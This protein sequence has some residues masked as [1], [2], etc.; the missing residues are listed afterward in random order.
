[1]STYSKKGKGWRYDFMLNG[2]RYTQAWFKTKREAK[3]A[4]T[5]KR[6][7]VLEPPLAATTD[8]GFLELVNRRLDHMKAYNSKAHYDD[9]RYRCKPWVQLWGHLECS[10]I[11]RE[12][13]QAFILKRSRV[14]ACTANRD[15]VSLRSLFNFGR[16]QNL[17]TVNPTEGIESLPIEKKVKY[18]PPLEDIF[19]VIA[20]AEPDTQDYLWTIRETMARVSE[21]N[22]L[23]WDDDVDLEGRYVILYTRKKK[24]GHLT[25]RKVPMTEHLF[26]I[27]SRRYAQRNKQMPYV[28]WY[29]YVSRKTGERCEG[30]YTRR[31]RLMKG[32]CKKAGVRYFNF[33]A[34]RHSGASV[35]DS[36]G[37][38]IGSIQRILGHENRTTT[39][40]YLQSIGDSERQAMAVFE[41]A[42]TNS[43]TD[44]HTAVVSK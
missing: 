26:K 1:M 18:I 22:R 30:P 7:E 44:S 38:P 15:M 2:V 21:V 35:M 10:E 9:Y 28:F 20:A 4:E 11:T 16:K 6:K 17:I 14:S 29:T 39:E 23:A 42:S 13:I 3:Q 19:K 24:G 5:D 43:H 40:I 37:V 8:M 25:P 27:L 31:K 34:L 12:M 33:H 36:L 41:A 32:L